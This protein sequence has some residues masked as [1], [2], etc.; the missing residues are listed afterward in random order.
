MA[1]QQDM[2]TGLRH[3]AIRGRDDEDRSIHLRCSGDHVLNVVGV[4][5]AVDMRIVALVGFVFDVGNVDGDATLSFF[6]RLVDLIIREKLSLTLF[7][8]HFCNRCGQ[9]RLA[10]IDMTDRADVE[11]W[12]L[13]LK[14]LFAHLI[15]LLIASQS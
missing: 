8:Q 7:F 13:T 3:R 4:T 2:L 15:L 1:R 5:R 9:G 12:F 10:M 6:R 14:L 11:V